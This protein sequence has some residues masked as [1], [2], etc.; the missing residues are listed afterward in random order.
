MLFSKKNLMKDFIGNRKNTK[1]D[2]L[3]NKVDQY[4]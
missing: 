3:K 1:K 4:I 2:N